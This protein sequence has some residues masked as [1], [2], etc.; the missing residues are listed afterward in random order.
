MYR[1]TF[2][3]LGKS[4]ELITNSQILFDY[5]IKYYCFFLSKEKK[6]HNKIKMMV[7]PANSKK[8]GKFLI[9]FSLCVQSLLRDNYIMLHGAAVAKNGKA[10]VFLGSSG[11]GK[12]TI[13]LFAALRGYRLLSDEICL[14]N[15]KNFTIAPFQ[16]GVTNVIPYTCLFLRDYCILSH[17]KR[18]S[19]IPFGNKELEIKDLIRRGIKFAEK[20]CP[21][22]EIYLF[23]KGKE[24]LINMFLSF[25][26][27]QRFQNSSELK[28]DLSFLCKLLNGCVHRVISPINLNT[29]RQRMLAYKKISQLLGLE[30]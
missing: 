1:T 19:N 30:V 9:E 13:S 18:K 16:R 22:D 28:K 15:K 2:N 21:I 7:R 27:R 5:L 6:S 3:F 11:S 10:K 17:S 4:I 23:C 25:R 8:I 20:E 24:S 12:T 14:V 29:K 26:Y